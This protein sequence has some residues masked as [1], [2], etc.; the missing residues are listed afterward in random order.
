MIKSNLLTVFL[1]AI[2]T[3]VMGQSE[4]KARVLDGSS[5]E[6]LVG[7]TAVLKG[8]TN[9]ATTDLEGNVTVAKIPNDQQILVISSIGY[10]TVELTLQFPLL[11]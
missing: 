9:G 6:P 8:T 5:R 10:Q 11:Q 3:L 1:L 7:A 4:F 2:T